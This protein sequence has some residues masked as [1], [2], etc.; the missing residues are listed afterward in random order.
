MA[1]TTAERERVRY[2][3]G[4]PQT[5]PVATIQYGLV[6]PI[7]TAFMIETAMNNLIAEAEPRVRELIVACD[8]IECLLREASKRL[9]ASQIDGIV[10]R[11]KEPQRLEEEYLRWAG[12]LA[13]IFGVPLYAYSNRFASNGSKAG[14]IPV[15]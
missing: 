12:R 7:Q 3:L 15:G 2:H 9:L 14:N 6:R 13:D 1:L 10:L 5:G 4:Y 11:D 8:D